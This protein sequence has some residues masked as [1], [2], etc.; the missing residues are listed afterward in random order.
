MVCI[1][2]TLN[3]VF[4][5]IEND[6][7]SKGVSIVANGLPNDLGKALYDEAITRSAFA[8]KPAG[9][10]RQS[11]YSKN[12][13]VRRDSIQWIEGETAAQ[14]DWLAWSASLQQHL[15]RTLLLGLFSFESHYAHYKPGA[16]YK[17]HL[18][19]FKGRANRVV[20]L[21]VYLNP[22]WQNSWGG[23][24]VIYSD[25]QPNDALAT[26]IPKFGTVVTFL[27]EDFPHEV[28]P[29]LHDRYSLAG[30]FRLNT[31]SHSTIDPPA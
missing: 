5:Q 15:N 21:V 1:E 12:D 10:G 7:R 8:F 31:T 27:S 29:S 20:S 6:L 26:V 24:L 25:T 16:F 14:A 3:P 23:E 19:S 17:T 22:E 11:D 13:D 30:W 4:E 28:K 2:V 18:D 9:V